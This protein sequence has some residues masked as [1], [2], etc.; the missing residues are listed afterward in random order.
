MSRSVMKGRTLFRSKFLSCSHLMFVCSEESE[1]SAPLEV[2]EMFPSSSLW[3]EKLCF[4]ES[5]RQTSLL[6][7]CGKLSKRD[8]PS[9]SLLLRHGDGNYC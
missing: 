4:V 8:C 2:P 1:N 5:G 9:L 3:Q 7:V 6:G